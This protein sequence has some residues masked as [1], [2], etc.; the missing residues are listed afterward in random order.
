MVV[1]QIILFLLLFYAA[2]KNEAIR[3]QNTLV[4]ELILIHSSINCNDSLASLSS[5]L[6]SCQFVTIP[7]N[8]CLI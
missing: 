5:N 8:C 7:L 1:F 2:R 6:F 4:K 3:G